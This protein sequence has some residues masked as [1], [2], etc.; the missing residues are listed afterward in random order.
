[1]SVKIYLIYDKINS[2]SQ[3]NQK[4]TF[5]MHNAHCAVLSCAMQRGE[6]K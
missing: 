4:V 3:G 1:M 6:K 2:I 5:G